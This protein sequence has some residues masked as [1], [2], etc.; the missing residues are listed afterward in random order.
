MAS[1]SGDNMWF[2]SEIHFQFVYQA[3]HISWSS[4]QSDASGWK[5]RIRSDEA[6]HLKTWNVILQQCLQYWQPE[7]HIGS[8]VDYLPAGLSQNISNIS[9]RVQRTQTYDWVYHYK[10]ILGRN[11]SWLS[12]R[13]TLFENCKKTLQWSVWFH[14]KRKLPSFL[15]AAKVCVY[16]VDHVPCCP[17]CTD[18]I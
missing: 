7:A 15:W 11:E 2:I 18:T 6:N 17:T 1:V 14:N 3:R 8:E 9:S 10:L 4:W 5:Y 16:S 13:V 12:G